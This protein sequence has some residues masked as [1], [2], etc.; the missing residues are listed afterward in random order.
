MLRAPCH[1]VLT[2]PRFRILAAA[3]LALAL[4]LPAGAYT[5]VFKDG[6]KIQ[7]RGK[8][9]LRDEKAIITLMS[10]TE[11]EYNADEIDLEATAKANRG[12]YEGVILLD[13][14]GQEQELAPPPQRPRDEGLAGLIQQRRAGIR[15]LPQDRRAPR[16]ETEASEGLPKTPAGFVDLAA[17]PKRVPADEARAA[18]LRDYFRRQKLKDVTVYRGLEEGIPLVEMRVSSADTAIRALQGA[19]LAVYDFTKQ[20]S[21]DLVGV[22]LILKTTEGER[23]GQFQIT[24]EMAE[25]LATKKIRAGEFF[26]AYVQF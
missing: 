19:A 24:P 13:E 10:G 12:G 16:A 25:D 26:V 9:D 3:L 2:E 4:A 5:I 1:R 20:G 17:M 14:S 11:T 8:W 7:S 6:T 18:A 23:A 21:S 15:Q 22:D